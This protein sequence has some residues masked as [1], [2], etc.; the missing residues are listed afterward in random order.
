MILR[1]GAA[2]IAPGGYHLKVVPAAGGQYAIEL[3][4]EDARNGHRPSVDMMFESLLPLTTLE[5]HAVIM[6]GMGS[7]GLKDDEVPI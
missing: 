1:Q 4:S 5:R 6:T 3:T 2:Y 7:D